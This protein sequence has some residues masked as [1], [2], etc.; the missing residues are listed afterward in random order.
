MPTVQRTK[1][2]ERDKKVRPQFRV[3]DI[4]GVTKRPERVGNYLIQEIHKGLPFKSL[5]KV[6]AALDLDE[7]TMAGLLGTSGRTIARRKKEKKLS[8]G[9]SDRL[10]RLARILDLAET[11]FEDRD[12][13]KEWLHTPNPALNMGTPLSLLDT[14]FGVNRVEEVLLRIEYGVYE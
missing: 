7:N 9:E 5:Q 14:D 10:A 8:S 12:N 13:A 6:R 3:L 1:K 4:L 2:R 11:V